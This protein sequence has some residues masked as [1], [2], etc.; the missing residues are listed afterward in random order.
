[1]NDETK[2]QFMEIFSRIKRKKTFNFTDKVSNSHELS[3]CGIL[4]TAYFYNVQKQFTP[5]LESNDLH[6]IPKQ[7]LHTARK[8]YLIFT[9]MNELENTVFKITS[10]LPI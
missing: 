5:S 6:L 7:R 2:N 1:M 9:K 10:H 8:H 3:T 4:I